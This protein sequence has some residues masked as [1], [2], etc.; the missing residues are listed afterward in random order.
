MYLCSEFEWVNGGVYKCSHIALCNG[1][2]FHGKPI[3]CSASA[4]GGNTIDTFM[5]I[6]YVACVH[7]AKDSYFIGT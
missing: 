6:H 5:R 4:T 7:T 2:A 1:T 3:Y